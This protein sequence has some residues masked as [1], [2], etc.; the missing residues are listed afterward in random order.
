[1]NRPALALQKKALVPLVRKQIHASVHQKIAD[2]RLG[3]N[4][5][6]VEKLQAVL[7]IPLEKLAQSL[8]MSRATL[9]RRKIQGRLDQDESE[10]LVRYQR[11][12]QRSEDV[13]GSSANAR[14]WLTH[15]QVGL[16]N[17]VPLDFATTELGAREVENLLGRVEYG[18]YS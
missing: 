14:A 6:E 1:M 15:P 13:F 5:K 11:L 12:L 7:G 2:I 8:G 4:F 16:G 9:H 17:V 10:K 18:V 3:L